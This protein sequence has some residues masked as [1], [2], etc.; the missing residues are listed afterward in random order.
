MGL[1]KFL[2]DRCILCWRKAPESIDTMRII[3]EERGRLM[4]KR[5]MLLRDEKV[6]LAEK[7]VLLKKRE[8]M[9][10]QEKEKLMDADSIAEKRKI[11]L[12][13]LKEKWQAEAAK[14]T[15][16]RMNIVA[17][18]RETTTIIDDRL[19]EMAEAINQVKKR[20]STHS[21]MSL[22]T[23]YTA[24]LDELKRLVDLI[25]KERMNGQTPTA[26]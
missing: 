6:L 25:D 15:Q 19:N 3:L 18:I 12:P 4:D 16:E 7:E 22:L 17:A 5:E 10:D 14:I 26:S 24:R 20:P 23:E 9:L 13:A 1:I 2:K 8:K 11:I 21:N